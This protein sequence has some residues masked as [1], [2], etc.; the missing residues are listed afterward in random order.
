MKKLILLLCLQFS[1]VSALYAQNLSSQG[2]QDDAK[3]LWNA[4]NEL[5]PGLYRHNDTTILEEKYQKLLVNFSEDKTPQETFLLLSEFT[6]AI[7]CGHT[8]LNP[9]N[10]KN[11][12]IDTLYNQKKLLPF[13]FKIIKN[14]WFV[15]KSVSD[16]LKKGD[17]IIS[18]NG[19]LIEEILKN[20]T[21][22]IQTDGGNQPQKIK[23][24]ELTLTSQYE[25]FDYYFPL[26][27]ELDS[28]IKL[29]VKKNGKE[30][31]EIIMIELL[32]KEERKKEFEKYFP[33]LTGNYDDLWKFKIENNQY[34]Y[35]KLGTFATNELSYDWKKYIDDVFTQINRQKTPHL[36]IDIR[37]NKGESKKVTKYLMEKIAVKEW[38][39]IFK[40]SY[41]A[42]NEVSDSLKTHLTTSNKRN[43]NASKWT[44]RWNENYRVVKGMPN[45]SKVISSKLMTYKGN[46][47]LLID[48]KTSANAFDLA[49][50]CKE[51]NFATLIGTNTGGTKQGFTA[52]RF[53]VL[54]LPNSNLQVDIPLIGH[55]PIQKFKNEGIEPNIETKETLEDFIAKKDKAFDTAIEIIEQV[56]KDKQ[57]EENKKLE[58]E[59]ENDQ[60]EEKQE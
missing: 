30:T 13:T 57:E 54:T 43:Y 31:T 18:I 2:L 11:R 3:L 51:N 59:L 35:L 34:A 1:F 29:E 47:Y 52:E 41:V 40:K 8:Y 44:K 55:Y 42:Y 10:Q 53:F 28:E 19:I 39:P 21:N 27:Y 33:L 15:Y 56:E 46:I 22:Y 12:I 16:N 4:L 60:N 38:K 37:G 7:K 36:I 9:F 32:T 24:T 50:N 45:E 5:H 49:E 58:E 20:I 26:L 6:A 23:E 17:E 14:Q 25:Y 48:E